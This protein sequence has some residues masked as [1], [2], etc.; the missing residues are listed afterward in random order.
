MKI[1]RLNYIL[2]FAIVIT[3]PLLYQSGSAQPTTEDLKREAWNYTKETKGI[4]PAIIAANAEQIVQK[5][6]R[7]NPTS[8]QTVATELTLKSASEKTAGMNII[9]TPEELERSS[10]RQQELVS[11]AVTEGARENLSAIFKEFQAQFCSHP[12]IS[13]DELARLRYE[14]YGTIF[15]MIYAIVVNHSAP[16]APLVGLAAARISGLIAGIL[17]NVGHDNFCRMPYPRTA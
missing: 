2:G 7:A 16:E 8:I 4:E 14:V 3:I 9:H 15:F 6:L 17:V 11:K 13:R 1:A 10:S 5:A 12:P